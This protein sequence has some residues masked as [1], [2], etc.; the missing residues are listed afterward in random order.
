MCHPW[1]GKIP[2]KRRWQT[3]FSTL[4]WEIPRTKAPGGLQS[5]ESQRVRQEQRTTKTSGSVAVQT[6]A[7]CSCATGDAETAET[8][9]TGG[10]HEES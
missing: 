9:K 6:Q 1:V 3:H 5:M 10:S 2:W 8:D 4:A 7:F